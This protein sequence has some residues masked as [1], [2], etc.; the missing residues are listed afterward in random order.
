MVPLS[1]VVRHELVEGAEQTT[2][3]EYPDT[4]GSAGVLAPYVGVI[5]AHAI[6]DMEGKMPRSGPT[7]QTSACTGGGGVDP[8]RR[9]QAIS[10]RGFAARLIQRTLWWVRRL[11]G[12][13]RPLWLIV[14]RDPIALKAAD[15]FLARPGHSVLVVTDRRRSDRREKRA[16]IP[17]ERRCADL[18]RRR[19]R[20][21]PM[22][23]C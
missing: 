6:E 22:G 21:G 19:R 2:L 20:V 16:P 11:L 14:A 17:F 9:R 13:K 15:Q 12:L 1:V 18:A 23:I 7:L 4:T 3:P 10:F 5:V 8:S